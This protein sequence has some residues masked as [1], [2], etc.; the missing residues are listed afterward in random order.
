MAQPLL[1]GKHVVKYPLIQGGMG[2]R[3]SAGNLAGHVAKCGGVGL[4]AA[5]GICLNSEFYNGRNY[6]QADAEAFKD[7]L[8]KA[9]EIAP[10]GVIGVNVMVALSDFESLVKAAIDGGTTVF[11]STSLLTTEDLQI[12]IFTL[13][14]SART[15]TQKVV[16]AVTLIA[17]SR[18]QLL[19]GFTTPTSTRL[20]S[21]KISATERNLALKVSYALSSTMT[22]NRGMFR[23]AR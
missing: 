19:K 15:T 4:V 22:S 23:P 7:E 8:R 3:V 14:T 18:T 10:D 1:I 2:V 20:T 6:F 17:S 9:Y 16:P 5:P 13:L 21:A 11:T 12:D